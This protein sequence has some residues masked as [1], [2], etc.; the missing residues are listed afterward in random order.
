MNFKTYNVNN[1][2]FR[3]M[4]G[5][6]INL[7]NSGRISI[8]NEATEL[9]ELKAGDR[10]VFQQDPLDKQNW[11]IEKV[12]TNEGFVLSERSNK[13]SLNFYSKKIVVEIL[14]SFNIYVDKSQSFRISQSP[15]E[16]QGRKLYLI[17]KSK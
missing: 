11:Y 1:A 10:I 6:S 8:S 9:M 4:R 14:R 2:Y 16:F 17:I 7:S 13:K 15:L 3:F 5:I 12:P